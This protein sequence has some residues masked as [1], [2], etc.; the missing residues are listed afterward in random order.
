MKKLAVLMPAYNAYEYLRESIDSI[1]EQDFKDFDLYVFDDCSTDNTETLVKSYH[2]PRMHYRRNAVNLG[3]SKTLNNGL[4]ELLP[5]YEYI[6]RMDAD[7]WCYPNRFTKQL[8]FFT[9]N[10]EIVL[11]ST[12]GYHL[13][14]IS[15]W[16]TTGW[17][18]PSNYNYI[19]YYLLLSTTFQHPTVMFKSSLFRENNLRYNENI[20]TCEDYEL[21]MRVVQLAPCDNLPDFLVKVRILPNSNHRSLANKQLHLIEKSRII[22]NYWKVYGV[23]LLPEDIL[24]M[25]FDNKKCD[26]N[27]FAIALR[28]MIGAFN[29][30]HKNFTSDLDIKYKLELRYI[31]ARKILNFWRRSGVSRMDLG[32]WLLIVKKV[33]FMN[34]YRIVRS[35][36]R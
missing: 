33:H 31:C 13:K 4:D 21:W 27:D 16:P 23:N 36:I 3:I 30:L 34:S 32:I 28:K 15:H 18:F 10:P 2:H 22:S 24:S 6:A 8:E 25:Y 11:C 7:D 1:L 26:R 29:D 20:Y 5:H 14:D 35:I 19:K 12:Q 17:T 9:N